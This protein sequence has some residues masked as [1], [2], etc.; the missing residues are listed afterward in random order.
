MAEFAGGRLFL[1][2][3]SLIA[4]GTAGFYYLPGMIEAD[5]AGSRLINS[6]YVSDVSMCMHHIGR[7]LKGEH[8][9]GTFQPFN[10]SY[11]CFLRIR[12]IHFSHAL[13]LVL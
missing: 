11:L 7:F 2:G 3:S 1:L 8:G 10:L 6:I 4:I 12:P 9:L 5:A 13:L